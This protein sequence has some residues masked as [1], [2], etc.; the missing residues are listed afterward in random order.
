MFPRYDYNK[1]YADCEP[2]HGELALSTGDTRPDLTTAAGGH[3]KAYEGY[4]ISEERGA[5]LVIRPDGCED[6]L[7]ALS[8]VLLTVHPD[9]ALVCDLEDTDKL[10]AYFGAFLLEPTH[11]IGAQ[12]EGDW[13]IKAVSGSKSLQQA[14]EIHAETAPANGA[15][16]L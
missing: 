5:L 11:P 4:G 9:I 14:N 2:W 13:T 8:I 3:G 6:H 7:A 10:D 16:V 1:I 15:A 12:T